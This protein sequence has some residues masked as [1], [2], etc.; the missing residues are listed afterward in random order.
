M[1]TKITRDI[2]ESYLNCKYKGHRS[3]RRSGRDRSP[4]LVDG[5]HVMEIV[6]QGHGV[7]G[8]GLTREGEQ[9]FG[10]AV[11]V[12]DVDGPHRLDLRAN[13]GPERLATGPDP[14][15]GNGKAT[16]SRFAGEEGKRRGVAR[17][18]LRLECV[19]PW[20]RAGKQSQL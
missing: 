18:R 8:L 12:V 3:G 5:F 4:C 14:D 1:A 20:D 16:G 13:F 2:I 6:R 17:Q 11:I 10:H 9:P 15:W 7:R 19:E